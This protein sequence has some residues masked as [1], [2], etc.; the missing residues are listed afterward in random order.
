MDLSYRRGEA[1]FVEFLDAR[2]ASNDTTQ[3]YNGARAE[4]ARSLHLIE[5]AIGKVAQ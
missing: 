2:R 4:H 3:S 5:S 1:S